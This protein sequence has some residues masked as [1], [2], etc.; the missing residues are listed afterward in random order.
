M[1]ENDLLYLS[2][3]DLEPLLTMREVLQYTEKANGL[4][5]AVMEAAAA[6]GESARGG[7]H[8]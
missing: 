4:P 7:R 3:R 1:A 6:P 5:V 2:R 8:T